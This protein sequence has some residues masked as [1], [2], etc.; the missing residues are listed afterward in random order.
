MV[1]T[2]PR[3][4][5]DCERSECSTDLRKRHPHDRYQTDTAKEKK[6]EA[7]KPV[8]PHEMDAKQ[9]VFLPSNRTY[10]LYAQKYIIENIRLIRL[11]FMPPSLCCHQR[12][13]HAELRYCT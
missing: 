13:T 1:S 3:S 7:V 8:F 6:K 10:L 4:G 5:A 12:E 2:D 11:P 9:S